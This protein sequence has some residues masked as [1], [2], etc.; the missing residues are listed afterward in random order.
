MGIKK[1]LSRFLFKNNISEQ[2]VN[3]LILSGNT[4]IQESNTYK[5]EKIVDEYM[6]DKLDEIESLFDRQEYEEIEDKINYIYRKKQDRFSEAVERKLLQYNCFL[7]LLTNKQERLSEYFKELEAYGDKTAEFLNVKFNIATFSQSDSIFKELKSTWESL[8]MDSSKIDS[9]EIKY[10]YFSKQYDVLIERFNNEKDLD[11]P[12]IKLYVAKSFIKIEKFDEAEKLLFEIKE[13]GDTYKAEYILCKALSVFSID[14]ELGELTEGEKVV[15]S[16]CIE[17]IKNINLEKLEFNQFREIS[18]YKLQMILFSD[19]SLAL[20]EITN[21]S[22]KF[23]KDTEFYV[24][25]IN[26]FNLNGKYEEADKICKYL[27]ETNGN[28]NIYI[29]SVINN[30]LCMEN[31]SKVKELFIKYRDYLENIDFAFY[32]YGFSLLNLHGEEYTN[33]VIEKECKIEGNLIDFL[34]AKA[35]SK[36]KEKSEFYLDKIVDNTKNKDL[37]LLDVADEYMN[38]D[39]T[40]KS[41]AIVKEN[42]IYDIR[43]LKRYIAIATSKNRK[44]YFDDILDIYMRCYIDTYNE[45]VERGIYSIYIKKKL[46]RGAYFIAK[47]AF[48]NT[49]KLYWL[50]ELTRMKLINKELND[51][52]EFADILNNEKDL[53]YLMTA[54]ETYLKLGEVTKAR[55]LSY[56]IAFNMN[57][58]DID[59]AVRIC[60]VL[61]SNEIQNSSDFEEHKDLIKQ[62]ELDDV[63]ILKSGKEELKVCLNKEVFYRINDIRFGCLHINMNE[64]LWIELLGSKV[65]DEINFKQKEYKIIEIVN[66]YDF[67]TRSCFNIRVKEK[68][69]NIKM[70]SINEKD[71]IEN[72]DN[73]LIRELQKDLDNLNKRL[74]GYSGKDKSMGGFELPINYLLPQI[75]NVNGNIDYLLKD[76]NLFFK[77]GMSNIIEKGSKVVL[78]MVSTLLLSKVNL[79]DEFMSYYDVYVPRRLIESIEDTISELTIDFSNKSLKIYSIEEKLVFFEKDQK[80]KK[81]E[82]KN[83]NKIIESLK[84]GKIISK[85]IYIKHYVSVPEQAMFSADMEAFEISKA[86]DTSIFID[87][88]FTC[89]LY[90]TIHSQRRSNM[91]GFINSILFNDFNKYWKIA[92]QLI[93]S[94]YEYFFNYIDL[95]TLVFNLDVGTR[96]NMKKFRDIFKIILRNDINGFYTSLLKQICINVTFR[97]KLYPEYKVKIDVIMDIISNLEK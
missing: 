30:C 88:K 89:L 71:L 87:D 10:L 84:K 14:R 44:E 72:T 68:D 96:N 46:Y 4:I 59:S 17:K 56:K 13:K 52:K 83:F 32:A 54:S 66:K 31:W 35:N 25:K 95:G 63:I 85:D 93:K 62:V 1:I 41:L 20:E 42:S 50:N 74:D 47:K 34:R 7:A 78:T 51:L 24:L 53:Q 37:I 80:E 22:D 40:E 8:D 12:E 45:Y 38:M 92:E 61:L 28:I 55:E 27:L 9:N 19:K 11:A 69:D 65:K 29:S 91:A 94:K 81:I 64:G 49:K 36:N 16:D 23:E 67:L 73:D 15:F 33:N 90:S 97:L 48:N 39:N 76:K 58:M 70:L 77:S 2:K 82:L 21:L 26:I 75:K 86:E 3:G 79:L 60:Q 6:K 43:F 57:N 5:N 18:Y